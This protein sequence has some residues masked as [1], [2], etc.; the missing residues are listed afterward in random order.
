[1][2]TTTALLTPARWRALEVLA[3]THPR[4]GRYGNE[5]KVRPLRPA[6]AS[7]GSTTVALVQC[8]AAD[9]LIEAGLVE[10]RLCGSRGGQPGDPGATIVLTDAGLIACA[11]VGIEVRNA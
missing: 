7:A 2:T 11:A 6:E 3:A 4:P 10:P 8:Q 1:M 9:W 5:T